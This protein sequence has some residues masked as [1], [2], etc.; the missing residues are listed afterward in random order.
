MIGTDCIDTIGRWTQAEIPRLMALLPDSAAMEEDIPQEIFLG[1]GPGWE[2]CDGAR[3]VS[4]ARLLAWHP[5]Q[6]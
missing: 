1:P 5:L 3:A 4:G 2:E 6:I